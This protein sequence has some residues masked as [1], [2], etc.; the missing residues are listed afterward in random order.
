MKINIGCGRDYKEGWLN[1]DISRDCKADVYFDIRKDPILNSAGKVAVDNSG[2]Y[3]YISGVLE[4]IGE[5]EHLIHAMNECWRV[6]KQGGIMEVVVPNARFAIAHQDPMDVRKF[7]KETFD[8]FLAGSRQYKLYGS[9]YG[10]KPWSEI[11][12]QENQR[13][14]MVIKMKK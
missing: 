1:T 11:T 14:I 8:Y 6:L 7:T 10:F 3:V 2:E 13:H 4:Q 9:V 12:I 5:N